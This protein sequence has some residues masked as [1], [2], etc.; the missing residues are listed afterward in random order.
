MST[1]TLTWSDIENRADYKASSVGISYSSKSDAKSKGGSP[2]IGVPATGDASSTTKSAISSGEIVI[3]G[4]KVDPNISHNTENAVNALGKI[5]DKKTVQE[6]QEL[7]KIF[8][9]EAYKLV[10]D[11]SSSQRKKAL[12]EAANAP[13]DSPEYKEAMARAAS[14]EDG[15][16]NKILLHGLVGGIM[17]DLGGSSFAS[18]A[19]GAGVNEAIQGELK[20][21]KDPGLHQWA[22]YIVGSA[23]ASIVGG[24]AQT[25]GS[26]AAS[27]TKNNYLTHKQYEQMLDE[28]SRCKTDEEK[29]IVEA[30]WKKID[31]EQDK[32]WFETHWRLGSITYANGTVLSFDFPMDD[33]EVGVELDGSRAFRSPMM[34]MIGER[35]KTDYNSL[36]DQTKQLYTSTYGFFHRQ[37]APIGQGFTSSTTQNWT[38]NAVDLNLSNGANPRLY[39]LGKVTGD[40]VWSF[41]GTIGAIGSAGGAIVTSPSGVGAVGFGTAAV[42]SGGIAATSVYNLSSDFS[43]IFSSNGANDDSSNSTGPS[44]DVG[45]TY[46]VN[47][48]VLTAKEFSDLRQQA[49]KQAWKNEQELVRTTG[50]GTI[51]WTPEEMQ[52]LINTGKVKGYEGHHMKSA[53]EYPDLA[54]DSRNIQFLKGR[55]MDVN[56]HLDAHGGNYQN[57]T[58][59][60]YN[61]E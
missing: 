22:S 24:N 53:A 20:K 52:E 36:W 44:S 4:V 13:I 3:G 46:N 16:A 45:K 40:V 5:F 9:E 51:D 25:G 41:G 34:I 26:T 23:A 12:K 56:E 38:L 47:G 61:P 54:G 19:I 28:L 1:G 15:G 57:S 50:K 29:A 11:I 60:P 42:Y 37:I 33:Q 10:G 7:A 31:E 59:G 14:W 6:Q 43:R 55:R 2:N 30:K 48:E 17:S 58:H 18:G 32:E 8:G 21:I 27:G 35:S 39:Y 49:I